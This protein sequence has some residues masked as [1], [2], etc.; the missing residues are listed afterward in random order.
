MNKKITIR[1]GLIIT[2]FLILSSS[3][4]APIYPDAFELSSKEEFLLGVIVLIVK[5][6]LTAPIWIPIVIVIIVM[7][8]INAKNGY[9]YTALIDA[10]KNGDLEKVKLLIENGAN[11]EVK[12][13]KGDT[14][15]ILA[16]YC[17]RLE[18]IKY[19]VEKGANINATND[20]GRT[21][22]MWASIWR[23]LE[24]VKLLIEIGA[25]V[26]IKNNYG[27]TVLDLAKTKEIKELLKKSGA[28]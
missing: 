16:S 2:A 1:I 28:K 10:S 8:S 25:D 14:A 21:A 4:F 7:N 26:N 18:I 17:R 9:G 12:D 27:K 6:V 11:I 5:I 22:L 13:N 15:L 23:D 20:N 3:L 24:M 19:L